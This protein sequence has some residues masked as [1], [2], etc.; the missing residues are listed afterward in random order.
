MLAVP[1]QIVCEE[2]EPTG[3]GLTV[4]VKVLDGP[5]QEAFPVIKLPTE[6]G[7]EPTV[8]VETIALV[9]VLITCTE[10]APCEAT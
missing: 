3:V 10:L 4:I 9:V 5:V 2:A 1:P 7:D 8:T 6:Y